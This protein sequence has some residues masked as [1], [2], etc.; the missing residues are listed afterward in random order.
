MKKL[1][2]IILVLLANTQSHAQKGNYADVN[3]VTIYYEIHGEGEPLLLLHG[4]AMSH[5]LWL[6]YQDELSKDYMMIIPDLRGHGKS[7]N[8][9]NDFTHKLAAEDMYALLDDLDIDK[10]NAMGF[11]SGAMTLTHMATID[12]SRIM[13]MVLIG[14][15]PF[16]PESCREL[17]KD[18]SF[19][20]ISEGWMKALTRQHPG[21]ESQIRS[22]LKQ[23]HDMAYSYDDMNFTEAYLSSINTPTFIIHGDRDEYFPIDL[24]VD[25][26]KS[27]PNS[28]LWI[29]PNHR[30]N[31]IHSKSIWAA[32]FIDAINQFF[33]GKWA[34]R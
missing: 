25:S 4:F 5:E 10:V 34:K 18:V 24:P 2:V 33:S 16:F 8:P 14:S 11:S 29:V 7:T 27:M 15:A 21:G 17:Q 31:S 6:W 28:Y 13:A 26:Y 19:E 22:L 12:T 32:P 30:H 3:G 1:A 20:T 9:S 23:F